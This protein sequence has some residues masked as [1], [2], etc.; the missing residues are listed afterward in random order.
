MSGKRLDG[1]PSGGGF[2]GVIKDFAGKSMTENTVQVE[3]DG[4]LTEV[5]TLVP[6][7]T[8]QDIT[9]LRALQ[10]GE[11]PERLV[12]K[13]ADFA[14]SR[15]NEGLPVFADEV[16]TQIIPKVRSMIGIQDEDEIESMVEYFYD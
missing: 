7:L 14:I 15:V 6:T 3:L 4:K 1:T 12:G 2:L 10:G 5:P 13:A 16:D 9:E 8:L 11:V